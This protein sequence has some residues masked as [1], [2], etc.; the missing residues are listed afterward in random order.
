VKNLFKSVLLIMLGVVIGVGW[1]RLGPSFRPAFEVQQAESGSGH[2]L[3]RVPPPFD[4]RI[5]KTYSDSQP[6]Y[7]R[8]VQAPD[9]APNVLLILTDDVGFAASSTFGGPVPTPNLDTLAEGGL[10]YTRFHTTAMCSPTRAAMLTGRNHHMVGNGIITDM[11]TGFPGYDGI[12]P[13][14]AA[15]I[16]RILTGNGFSTAFFGKHHNV[17]GHQASAAGPFDLW[18]TGLGFEY[19]YGFLG[20]DADQYRP[21]LY[22]GIQQAELPDDPDYLLDKDLADDM[23]HWLRRQQAAA[24]NKPFMAW[25]SPGTAHAPHQAPKE[26]IERFRGD[27]SGGWDQLRVDSFERQKAAGLIPPDTILTPRPELV[28]AW[29]SLSP[30]RRQINERFMEVFAA[31]LAYQDAQIGRVFDELKRI[32]EFDDTLIIFVQGD[33]GASAEGAHHGT[34]NEL[35]LLVNEI[36]EPEDYLLAM[37]DEM[38]GP[39][40]YQ[41]YP[42]GWAWALD[43]PFQ[44]T[45][46]VGSHLGGTRNGMVVSWPD[47]ISASGEIRQQ[48]H[49]VIDVLPTVLEATGVTAP[50]VVDGIRQQRIDGISM[51][52]SFDQAEAAERRITQYFELFGNRAIYHD[53]WMA[54]T[55]PR[56]P[57]WTWDDPS[58]TPDDSYH[59]ELYHLAEDFSQGRD[60]AQELPDRLI[61]M[62]ARFWAEAERN[63][64]LPLDDRRSPL[65]VV[66]RYL[67]NW[68]K[69]DEYVFQGPDISLPF[70][71]APPLFARD[72]TISADIS[73]GEQTSGVLVGFGSWFGGWS[74]YLD[75]GVPVVHHSFNQSPEDQ[76]E[77]R[78]TQAVPVGRHTLEFRFDYDGG[79]LLRGGDME[80]L[81]NGESLI[82]GRID[83]TV[84]V[85]AGLG[86][87]FD[88]GA[89][90]GVPVVDATAGQLPFT[91][92]INKLEVR[93][94]P[95]GLL[96]F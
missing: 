53:G 91:G 32:G 43:T 47:G 74:F 3:P 8:P 26:W 46:T 21:N 62:Q 68:G 77:I 16:G 4:G 44:W 14:S 75:E 56:I 78:A 12:I 79:G 93:P 31:T 52:Y 10:R 73:V 15:T 90:L 71:E 1:F 64:V 42:I 20:G 92:Q 33:N 87:T 88:I 96:P 69:R 84:T 25:Y 48:F 29:D 63:N 58:G 27:F 86:E 17:P 59:W 7:P 66:D 70:A 49:H 9:G 67:A 57:P 54:S 24:P 18:P 72:F 55:T 6:S 39:K 38:G 2:S 11:A 45:K 30:A 51:L 65:R 23:I 61:D 81:L 36:E 41:T 76:Y 35:G 34:L 50:D 95:L 5:G 82:T 89:D 19:F 85:V 94:G 22:R 37:L 80:I 60:L 13:K 28:A 40:S 83:K